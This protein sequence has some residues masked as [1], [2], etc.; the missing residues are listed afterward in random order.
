MAAVSALSLIVPVACSSSGGPQVAPCNDSD[1]VAYEVTADVRGFSNAP[2]TVTV[3]HGAAR[4]QYRVD[5]SA[6]PLA[7]TTSPA[8]RLPVGRCGIKTLPGG[9]GYTS[10]FD[11]STHV[12]CT[13]LDGGPAFDA[14]RL[15]DCMLFHVT[16]VGDPASTTYKA[17]F[18]FSAAA[19]FDL[20]T[21]ISCSGVPLYTGIVKRTCLGPM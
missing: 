1:A 15:D 18:G 10:A 3:S 14:A 21:D 9:V 8:A 6:T 19:G 4:F 12:P 2:C 5:P 11:N 13:P 7:E 17:A 20:T 16:L